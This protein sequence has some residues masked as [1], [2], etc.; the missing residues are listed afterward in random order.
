MYLSTK[1][2]IYDGPGDLS[3][4]L[5]PITKQLEMNMYLLSSFKGLVKIF[6]PYLNRKRGQPLQ[7]MS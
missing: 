3:N 4:I 7:Y 2:V 5:N 1:Y 6:Y